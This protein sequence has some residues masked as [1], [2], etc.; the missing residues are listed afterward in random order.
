MNSFILTTLGQY[1]EL[2]NM[3]SQ[4]KEKQIQIFQPNIGFFL[5][6]THSK[7][8]TFEEV[9]SPYDEDQFILIGHISNRMSLALLLQ[10]N[11]INAINYDD[12]T[13]F[14]ALYKHFGAR[15]FWLAEGMYVALFFKEKCLQIYTSSKPG[16]PVYYQ[17]LSNGAF[18]A[19]NEAKLLMLNQKI[20]L[21]LKPI[22]SFD[23]FSDLEDTFTLFQ[24]LHKMPEYSIMRLDNERSSFDSEEISLKSYLIPSTSNSDLNIKKDKLLYLLQSILENSVLDH[25]NLW[26]PQNSYAVALS[27]GIDSGIMAALLRKQAPNAV[28]HSFSIGSEHNNEFHYARICADYIGTQHHELLIDEQLFLTALIN[29]IYYNEIFDSAF[30]EVTAPFHWV[31][32]AAAKEASIMLTGFG[33]DM[34]FAGIIDPGMTLQDINKKLS[35]KLARTK[36]TGEFNPYLHQHHGIDVRHPFLNRSL[37]N[38]CKNMDP[39]LKLKEGCVKYILKEL[40]EQL[41]LLPPEIIWREKVRLE[42]GMGNN[43]MFSKF[44]GLETAKSYKRKDVFTYELFK[45]L[46]EHRVP[47]NEINPVKIRD[48]IQGKIYA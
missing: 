13:L 36:W 32:Q 21:R 17:S 38:V 39:K 8:K 28:I 16:L 33:A 9:F 22:E 7:G 26:E 31:Y 11:D 24:H 18:W 2:D 3:A 45:Q 23:S 44:L 12:Q 34:N 41:E 25:A 40:A 15:A 37:I 30:A 1:H 14:L 48:N 43:G 5:G 20:D 42:V 10:N 27:G 19:S 4:A 35:L 46:F 47:L 29:V 6:L